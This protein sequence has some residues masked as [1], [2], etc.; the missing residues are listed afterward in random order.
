[1]ILIHRY[2]ADLEGCRL[3]PEYDKPKRRI[4][5][6]GRGLVIAH[7]Q[8]DLFQALHGFRRAAILLSLSGVPVLARDIARVQRLPR[9][10]LCAVASAAHSV[11]DRRYP[12]A[13]PSAKAPSTKFSALAAASRWVKTFDWR[14]AVFVRRFTKSPRFGLESLQA[15][16]P[17]SFGVLRPEGPNLYSH[18]EASVACDSA[19]LVS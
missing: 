13:C 19:L 18:L 6:L 3:M 10:S 7:S 12:P 14:R 4:K 17:E 5:S 8:D 11:Q 1:M 15:K 9:S 16:T 2:L